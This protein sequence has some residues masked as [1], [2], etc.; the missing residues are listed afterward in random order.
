MIDSVTLFVL[1]GIAV[2]IALS[3]YRVIIGPTFLERIIALDNI[4]NNIVAAIVVF[5]I[6]AKQAMYVDTALVITFCLFSLLSLWPNICWVELCS[7]ELIISG[8]LLAGL[9]FLLRGAL[10]RLRL[11]D[12]YSRTDTTTKSTTLGVADMVLA[13]LFSK[14]A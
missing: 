6:W 10:G 1:F 9:F 7:M 2:C 12:V 13:A 3:A 4:L 14:G 8:F 11:K 5:A